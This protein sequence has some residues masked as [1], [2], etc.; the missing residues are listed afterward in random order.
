MFDVKYSVNGGKSKVK[1]LA[2]DD[3]AS[4]EKQ[5]RA[6]YG[7]SV[8]V[9]IE[10]IEQTGLSLDDLMNKANKTVLQ[11][12]IMPEGLQPEKKAK[13][14]VKATK[15]VTKPA[16]KAKKPV[17]ATKKVV[18]YPI[19]DLSKVEFVPKWVW[20]NIAEKPH[21]PAEGEFSYVLIYRLIRDLEPNYIKV[22]CDV[23]LDLIIRYAAE[24]P[25]TPI[26]E[27]IG[28]EISTGHKRDLKAR[29]HWCIVET[30]RRLDAQSA[31]G[32]K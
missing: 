6:M 24:N 29:L 26:G 28:K 2:G 21:Q 1:K 19:A 22:P 10:S 17:K 32:E 15:K 4:V 9:V 27:W 18:H 12:K 20:N 25:N 30:L 16:P 31:K 14:P 23:L 7:K 3:A 13:K 5:L 11:E 8:N